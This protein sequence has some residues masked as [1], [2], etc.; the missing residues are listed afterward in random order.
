MNIKLFG[1]TQDGLDIYLFEMLNKKGMQ[2]NV[3]NYGA[4][5]VNIIAP[6]RHGKLEDVALG[7]DRLEDYLNDTVYFGCIVGRYGNRIAKGRFS[8]KGVEYKLATNDGE[9]HLHGGL[10][11]FNKKIWQVYESKNLTRESVTFVCISPDGEEGYPGKITLEVTYSLTNENELIIDYRGTTDK[12]T[13]LNPT[14]HAYFN[15]TGDFKKTILNNELQMDADHYTPV[16]PGSIPIG[17]IAP[18]KGTPMDFRKPTLL[19]KRI[20]SDFDQLKYGSGYDHNWVF[21]NF[22]RQVKHRATLYEPKCGR[23]L[24]LFT[25]QPGVQ[26]YTGNFLEGVKNGK[27]GITYKKRSAV[28][29]EAQHFPDSPNQQNFPSVVLQPG[30][31]YKQ[32]TIYKFSSR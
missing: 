3:T 2:V 22:D 13:I 26:M 5:I 19:G 9:N 23:L 4:T 12:T 10:V 27:N 18:V 31:E 21:N 25:D 28:C 11:G 30:E 7:Y 24:E 32:T 8:L 17:E 20:E 16:Q 6:D 15:L 1:K 14:N 29:L